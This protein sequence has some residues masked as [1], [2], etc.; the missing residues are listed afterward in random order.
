MIFSVK[1]IALIV[2]ILYASFSIGS[3]LKLLQFE[4]NI[5]F[6]LILSFMMPFLLVGITVWILIIIVGRENP[7]KSFVYLKDIIVSYPS[8]VGLIGDVASECYAKQVAK[9]LVYKKYNAHVNFELSFSIVLK[10]IIPDFKAMLNG[11]VKDNFDDKKNI[12][13]T[14]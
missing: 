14:Y 10:S 2:L 3:F 5:W 9:S 4:M 13:K 6:T 1:E 8:L 12:F 7:W 11:L